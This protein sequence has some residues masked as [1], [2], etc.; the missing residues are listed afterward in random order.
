MFDPETT[1]I[2]LSL[3]LLAAFGAGFW[4]DYTRFRHE[5]KERK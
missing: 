4:D 5:R 2:I 3:I 1:S